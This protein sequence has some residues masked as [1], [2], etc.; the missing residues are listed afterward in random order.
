MNKKCFLMAQIIAAGCMICACGAGPDETE[1]ASNTEFVS[2]GYTVESD[3]MVTESTENTENTTFSNAALGDVKEQTVKIAKTSVIYS[4]PDANASQLGSIEKGTKVTALGDVDANG[5]VMVEYNGRAA[6]I[7]AESAGITL[8]ASDTD[9]DSADE[10]NNDS[11][12]DKKKKTTS[13]TKNNTD[14]KSGTKTKNKSDSSTSGTTQPSSEPA[15]TPQ[16]PSSEPEPTP[17]PD[18]EPEPTPTPDPEPEPT[19]TPDPEPEPTPTPDPEP[20]PTPDSEPEQSSEQSSEQ[21]P[22]E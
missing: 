2:K 8:S 15:T 19:P 20:T 21:T 22:A 3:T 14:T 11:S 7:K 9:T 1:K 18:P 6:Y 16:T 12:S 4:K 5:W 17:T 10:S 13:D